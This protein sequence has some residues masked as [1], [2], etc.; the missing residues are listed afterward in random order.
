MN[1][2][3]ESYHPG[4][5]SGSER[6]VAFRFEEGTSIAEVLNVDFRA[7]GVDAR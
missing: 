7:K 6:K 3:S 1:K 5:R 2:M 4:G